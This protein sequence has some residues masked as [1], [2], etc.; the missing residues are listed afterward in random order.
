M[1]HVGILGEAAGVVRALKGKSCFWQKHIT[2]LQRGGGLASFIE[3]GIGC[4]GSEHKEWDFGFHA[5]EFGI[6]VWQFGI[7]VSV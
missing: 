4:C 2:H 1:T 5:D 7:G 3:F 6:V